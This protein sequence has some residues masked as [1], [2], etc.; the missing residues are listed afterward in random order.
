[1]GKTK[2]PLTPEQRRPYL[3]R[4]LSGEPAASV[5]KAARVNATTLYRWAKRD[6]VDL[7]T[8]HTAT[9]EKT[10]AAHDGARLSWAARKADMADKI[11]EVAAKALAVCASSLDEGDPRSAKD[12]ALTLGILTDKA[13]L[14][15]GAA[16]SRPATVDPAAAVAAGRARVSV[17]HL[18]PVREA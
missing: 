6:G 10:M 17:L 14:L 3:D 11:G 9:P 7:T 18:A 4:L 2:P 16:T 8:R 5:A 13:Q 15:T 1:M 12:A